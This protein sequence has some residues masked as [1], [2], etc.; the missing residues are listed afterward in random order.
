MDGSYLD[1]WL[2]SVPAQVLVQEYRQ[3]DPLA[4]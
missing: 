3:T 4:L 2:A 1:T